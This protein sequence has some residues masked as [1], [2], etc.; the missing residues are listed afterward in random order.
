[1]FIHNLVEA[2]QKYE[3]N[4]EHTT[5]NLKTFTFYFAL[6]LIFRNFAEK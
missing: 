3:L 5:I 2:N 6:C 1:M 4:K